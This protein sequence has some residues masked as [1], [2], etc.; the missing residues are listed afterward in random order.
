MTKTPWLFTFGPLVLPTDGREELGAL[1]VGL[2]TPE[3]VAKVWDARLSEAPRVR[4]SRRVRWP[5]TC[6][7]HKG[8]FILARKQSNV[9]PIARHKP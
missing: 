1:A 6:R 5:Q 2:S 7:A 4:H 3:Y 8:P 9:T